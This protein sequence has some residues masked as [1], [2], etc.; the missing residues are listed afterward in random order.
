[1]KYQTELDNPKEIALAI[2]QRFIYQT[3]LFPLDF[4]DYSIFNLRI[5]VMNEKETNSPT[6][7]IID[8]TLIETDLEVKTIETKILIIETEITLEIEII[9]ITKILLL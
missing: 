6:I 8:L 4:E 9:V 2:L 7:T 5:K 1:Y 3:T